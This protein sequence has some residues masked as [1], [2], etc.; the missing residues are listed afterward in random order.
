MSF[1]QYITAFLLNWWVID[2]ALP[3]MIHL[4][5]NYS[6]DKQMLV[7]NYVTIPWGKNTY[8]IVFT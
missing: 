4:V 1:L 6:L 8:V 2:H 3:P 7:S 5:V